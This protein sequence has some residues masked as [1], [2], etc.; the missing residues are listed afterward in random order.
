[1]HTSKGDRKRATE[2]DD[3]GPLTELGDDGKS[4]QSYALTTLEVTRSISALGR[5]GD[6]R[7]ELGHMELNYCYRLLELILQDMILG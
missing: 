3:D 5:A 4:D 2:S 1:M 7:G 6:A